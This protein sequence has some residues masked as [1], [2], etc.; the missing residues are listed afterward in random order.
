M[1]CVRGSHA[2][3]AVLRC[4]Q[5]GLLCSVGF[6]FRRRVIPG[7]GCANSDHGAGRSGRLGH[8]E[9]S[10]CAA[11]NVVSSC[12]NWVYSSAGIPQRNQ[13]VINKRPPSKLEHADPNGQ[14]SPAW[15]GNTSLSTKVTEATLHTQLSLTTTHPYWGS[16]RKFT[17]PQQEAFVNHFHLPEAIAGLSVRQQ[18][19]S[20]SHSTPELPDADCCANQQPVHAAEAFAAVLPN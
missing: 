14:N 2:P 4:L 17:H 15:T 16:T 5:G 6:V 18:Q 9:V 3:G 7:P 8:R 1:G 20:A 11:I 12:C 10:S 13:R 19:G